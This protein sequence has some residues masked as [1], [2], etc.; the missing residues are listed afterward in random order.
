VVEYLGLARQCEFARKA[1]AGLSDHDDVDREMV[2]KLFR[3][4]N[5]GNAEDFR[6]LQPHRGRIVVVYECDLDVTALVELAEHEQVAFAR[7]EYGYA[8]TF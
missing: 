8:Y 2:G 7:P 4:R 5:P 3:V 1:V 6:D